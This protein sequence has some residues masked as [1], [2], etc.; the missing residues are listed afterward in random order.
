VGSCPKPSQAVFA[1]AIATVAVE[2]GES[3]RT[4]DRDHVSS[5]RDCR[6][7]ASIEAARVSCAMAGMDRVRVRGCEAPL[8]AFQTAR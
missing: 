3:K 4:A 2:T 6:L 7:A 5:P 1:G 8:R